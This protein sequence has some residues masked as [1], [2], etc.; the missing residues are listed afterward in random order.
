MVNVGNARNT[1][2]NIQYMFLI[3]NKSKNKKKNNVCFNWDKRKKCLHVNKMIQKPPQCIYS[4]NMEES[5][6]LLLQWMFCVLLVAYDMFHL[7]MKYFEHDG[8][9]LKTVLH[10]KYT[11]LTCICTS[12]SSLKQGKGHMGELSSYHFLAY[13]IV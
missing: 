10:P 12:H 5:A 11:C 9:K 1:I 2:I 4:I 3:K 13:T 6:I 8:Y 7:S